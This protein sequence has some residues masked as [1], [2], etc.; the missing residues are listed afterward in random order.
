MKI[1][2]FKVRRK[3]SNYNIHNTNDDLF[4]IFLIIV[5]NYITFDDFL[6]MERKY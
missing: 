4:N 1:R 6:E 5:S 3:L 2:I